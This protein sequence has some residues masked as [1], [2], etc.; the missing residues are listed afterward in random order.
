[1]TERN[2]GR[3]CKL[4]PKIQ[5]DRAVIRG[6]SFPRPARPPNTL[7]TVSDYA[8]DTLPTIYER[9]APNTIGIFSGGEL[10]AHSP[11][12]V[13]PVGRVVL[14]QLLQEGYL[15]LSGLAHGVIVADHFQCH[16]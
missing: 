11:N 7:G 12:T 13:L 15:L 14:C 3:F 10:L 16:L 6:R 9:S 4:R 2:I 8:W 5:T 1:M